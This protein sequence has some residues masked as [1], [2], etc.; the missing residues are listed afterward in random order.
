MRVEF[1]PTP[2]VHFTFPLGLREDGCVVRDLDAAGDWLAAG[3]RCGFDLNV[4]FIYA[5]E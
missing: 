1:D 2:L 4:S 5:L 3:R